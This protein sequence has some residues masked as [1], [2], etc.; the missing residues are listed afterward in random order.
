MNGCVQCRFNKIIRAHY[1]VIMQ[2]QVASCMYE[3]LI[4][5]SVGR[6]IV[7]YSYLIVGYFLMV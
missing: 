1:T 3:L 4:A 2:L 5:A 6:L 7:A